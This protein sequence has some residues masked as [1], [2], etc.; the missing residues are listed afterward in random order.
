VDGQLRDANA[1]HP[2][3]IFPC[4]RDSSPLGLICSQLA[5]SRTR[6][7][8]EEVCATCRRR[9]AGTQP[10]FQP[11]S[12]VLKSAKTGTRLRIHWHPTSN[13]YVDVRSLCFLSPAWRALKSQ[14][15]PTRCAR[16][17][18]AAEL[19]Q[20]IL[21]TVCLA[22][23]GLSR[24]KFPR[25]KWTLE[26]HAI[27]SSIS[28]PVFRIWPSPSSALPQSRPS[29]CEAFVFLILESSQLGFGRLDPKSLSS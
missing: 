14:D 23:K 17:A 26:K 27:C 29:Q 5:Y 10:N 2:P 16:S 24:R 7:S 3:H 21:H 25:L 9:K 18:L 22:F 8:H 1:H 4:Q 13:D 15:W 20:P 19:C 28:I 12:A 6:T 11:S